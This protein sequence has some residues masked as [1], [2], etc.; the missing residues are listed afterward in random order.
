MIESI[1]SS[2]FEHEPALETI[3]Q[4]VEAIVRR[5]QDPDSFAAQSHLA[6]LRPVEIADY[7]ANPEYSIPLI[8]TFMVNP[9]K[10]RYQL[11]IV[12]SHT[13]YHQLTPEI[14]EGLQIGERQTAFD[15]IPFHSYWDL[16]Y[17]SEAYLKGS[18]DHN[19]PLLKVNDGDLI[20]KQEGYKA[21]LALKSVA[22]ENGMVVAG[23]WYSPLG[24]VKDAIREGFASG[25]SGIQIDSG[26]L[27][28]MRALSDGY[29]ARRVFERAR[30]YANE[31]D[32]G[33]GKIE[34]IRHFVNPKRF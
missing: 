25:T 31:E 15:I 3:L 17:R 5:S 27:V 7:I 12:G 4:R 26:K 14:I 1:R 19:K 22:D 33:Q 24:N 6:G 8:E 34:R 23:N 28:L 2:R 11:A 32:F 9:E 18:L 13:P 29:E 21:L 16:C 20:V 10:Y 30:A